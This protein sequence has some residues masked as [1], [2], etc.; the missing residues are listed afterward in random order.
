[1]TDFKRDMEM[2]TQNVKVVNNGKLRF[3]FRYLNRIMQDSVKELEL[4]QRTEN[5]LIRNGIMTVGDL[6]KNLSKV[7]NLR[8][9]GEVTAK[10]VNTMFMSYYYDSLNDAERNEFWTDMYEN[11][12]TMTM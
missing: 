2:I 11:T 6:F 12:F 9:G 8:G 7:K 4:K 5:V 1:M 3:S 10:N